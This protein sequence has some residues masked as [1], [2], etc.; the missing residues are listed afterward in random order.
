MNQF[1]RQENRWNKTEE[2]KRWTNWRDALTNAPAQCENNESQSQIISRV[3]SR[4]EGK[5]IIVSLFL[6][7]S[8]L[9]IN[10]SWNGR[11]TCYN[12]VYIVSP[13]STWAQRNL[14]LFF[15]LSSFFSDPRYVYVGFSSRARSHFSL[16]LLRRSSNEK[17]RREGGNKF[18]T[19]TGIPSGSCRIGVGPIMLQS[20]ATATQLSPRFSCGIS[21]K[22]LVREEKANF[23]SFFFLFS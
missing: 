5:R 9:R 8:P 16:R 11:G 15:F 22:T 14:L 7:P 13:L 12:A 23:F 6:S 2:K 19:R 4:M 10:Y 17:Y 21:T 3:S 18:W 1:D 20:F